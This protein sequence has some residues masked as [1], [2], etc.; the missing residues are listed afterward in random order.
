MTAAFAVHDVEFTI[1]MT[2]HHGGTAIN[3]AGFTVVPQ[4]GARR[5]RLPWAAN[6]HVR[7][8]SSYSIVYLMMHQP[9]IPNATYTTQQRFS[10]RKGY[11]FCGMIQRPALMSSRG[12]TTELVQVPILAFISAKQIKRQT[13]NFDTLHKSRQ[14]YQEDETVGEMVQSWDFNAEV[15]PSGR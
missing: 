12:P 13:T 4:R 8:V 10:D 6:I 9:N 1:L 3:P 7:T 15:P 11:P 2:A 5:Q 14:F